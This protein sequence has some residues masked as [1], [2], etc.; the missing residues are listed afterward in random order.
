MPLIGNGTRPILRAAIPCGIS[1]VLWAFLAFYEQVRGDVDIG[2]AA[3]VFLVNLILFFLAGFLATRGSGGRLVEGLVASFMAFLIFAVGFIALQ[4][5]F[6]G[7][8][9][10]GFSGAAIDFCVI[11]SIAI[12]VGALLGAGSKRVGRPWRSPTKGHSEALP[13]N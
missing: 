13:P 10:E 7:T 2:T 1:L 12:V 9:G 3:G 4:L 5:W 8:L 11:W 6:A